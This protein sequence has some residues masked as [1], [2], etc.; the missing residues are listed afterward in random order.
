MDY[1]SEKD[2]L[3]KYNEKIRF[4]EKEVEYYKPIL[5]EWKIVKPDKRML[6]IKKE[7]QEKI[8]Q[9]E[10]REKAKKYIPETLERFDRLKSRFENI[11]E[12]FW[13]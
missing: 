2:L 8:K 9:E 1:S 4:L 7:Y 5:K 3:E 13:I 11:L 12:K 6:E 10:T